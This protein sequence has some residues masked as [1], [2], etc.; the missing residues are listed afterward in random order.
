MILCDNQRTALKR[1]VSF[2]SLEIR[3][4]E[5]TLGDNPSVSKGPP[6][7]LSWDYRE[8]GSMDL[9][10]FESKRGRRRS[11]DQMMLGSSMRQ[12]ILRNKT[13][14]SKIDIID[15]V[16]EVKKIKEKRR[17]SVSLQ[18]LDKFHEVLESASRKIK[19]TMK[20]S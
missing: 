3:E 1:N 5:I 10:K 19:R 15:A 7:S 16:S 11:K 8:A 6:I 2:S 14:I 20:R 9:E 12:Q 17:T 18:H 4:Y 13:G